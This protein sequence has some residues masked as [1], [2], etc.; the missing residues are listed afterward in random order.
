VAIRE[1]TE[2][3]LP[4]LM[5]LLRGYADFYECEPSDQ[6][7]EAMAR[8][9][10]AGPEERAFILVATNDEDEVIGFALNQW[11]WSSLNGAKVVYLDDLFVA[12][13]ARG[14]GHADALIEAT[15]EVGRRHGAAAVSW[16]TMPDNHRAHT[17]YDRVGGESEQ[18]LEYQLS[19]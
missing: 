8:D 7:L 6:G 16:L 10:I 14:Q 19:L 2:A 15:A 11:K 17:V 3:D 18:L 9:I 4:A 5:P 12:E 1:A 13:P